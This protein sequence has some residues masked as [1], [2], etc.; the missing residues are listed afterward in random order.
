MAKMKG[1]G[2]LKGLLLVHGEKIGIFVVGLAVCWIIFKGMTLPTLDASFQADKLNSEVTQTRNDIE[3]FSWEKAE[4]EQPDKLKKF[5]PVAKSADLTVKAA[6]YQIGGLD[7]NVI[8]AKVLRSDPKIVNAIEVVARG[9]SGPLAFSD[10]KIRREQAVRRAAEEAERLKKEEERLAKEAKDAAENRGRPAG[11]GEIGVTEVIDP[12]HPNR[13]MMQGMT[14][15]SGV[16]LQGGERIEPAYW[17]IVTAKVPIR[18]QMKLNK[19]AFGLSYDPARDFPQ[20]YGYYVERSEVDR[21]KPLEWK[22]VPLYDGQRASMPGN[23][24][25]ASSVSDR[26]LPKL[27]DAITKFWA[28]GSPAADV[29]DD[30][31]KDPILTL[32]LPPL[33]GR[34]WGAEATHPDIPLIW[35]TPPL[36]EEIPLA[37]QTPA[38]T[39]PQDEGSEFGGANQ[40]QTGFYPAPGVGR[41][42][43][44]P[45]MPRGGEFMGGRMPMIG[46]GG[47]GE[48]G[49]GPGR[50][51]G[52]PEGGGR[53]Y[54]GSSGMTMGQQRTSLPKNVDYLLLRFVD[55][56]VE[57]GKKY[58]YRVRLVIKDPNAGLPATSLAEDVLDRQKKEWDEDK[59]RRKDKAVR[60]DYRIVETFSDPSPTVG[61]PMAGSVRVAEAKL[62]AAEK[63]NDEPSLK[64]LVQSFDLDQQGNAIQ[65]GKE[66]EFRRGYVANSVEDVRYI[67][68]DGTWTDE[69]EG[70]KLNTGIT[71]LDIDGGEK[72]SKDASAPVRAL[73]MGPSG[74]LYVRKEIDDKAEIDYHRLIFSDDKRKPGQFPGMGPEGGPEMMPGGPGGRGRRSER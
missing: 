18:E 41:G 28:N 23:P 46:R 60:R 24:I 56:S 37:E 27:Y 39:A 68:P 17:A 40:A 74:E 59:E 61:I 44:M 20:Y 71:L 13:R 72:L 11:P 69:M 57:P 12:E 1:L 9:G 32:P 62:P 53:S 65:A 2:G 21:S 42:P 58:K 31:Y 4:A 63:F 6:P 67:G 26:I 3:E 49:M 45:G 33:V 54:A 52:G 14:R 35:N 25:S 15:P 51:L 34:D 47:M 19:D 22:I 43:G 36:E 48:P 66:R 73:L 8:A 10:E 70:F 64:M 5:Q 29:V 30:R 16:P 55:Y 7:N 50:G 38:A